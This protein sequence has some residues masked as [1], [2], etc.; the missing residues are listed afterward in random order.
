MN[1]FWN[2]TF[3][4][5]TLKDWGIALGIIAGAFFILKF[6][7]MIALI[8]LKRWAGKTDATFDDFIVLALEKYIVP[9]F[10]LLSVYIGLSYL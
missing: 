10:Y 9:F 1:S 5:N 6:V 8:Q 3:W 2:Y 7:K 4:N